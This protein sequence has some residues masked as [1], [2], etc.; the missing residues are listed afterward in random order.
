METLTQ[1]NIWLS[2]YTF[3]LKMS[4]LSLPDLVKK[5]KKKEPL[6]STMRETSELWQEKELFSS[7]CGHYLKETARLLPQLLKDLGT[8]SQKGD[9][10]L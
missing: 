3:S 4:A 6:I 8:Y 7:Y 10:V 9:R 1:G 2:Y 5:K